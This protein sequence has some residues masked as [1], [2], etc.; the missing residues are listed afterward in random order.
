[1]KPVIGKTY[2]WKQLNLVKFT[3]GEIIAAVL[4]GMIWKSMTRS[5]KS[6][7][8]EAAGPNL[9]R[10]PAGLMN[11]GVYQARVTQGFSIS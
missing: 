8:H 4:A 7:P 9:A 5:L 2:T 6:S 3:G 10:I 11:D 1:V